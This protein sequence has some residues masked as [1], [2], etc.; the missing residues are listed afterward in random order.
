MNRMFV[1]RNPYKD[2]KYPWVVVFGKY[3]YGAISLTDA[4]DMITRESNAQID[5]R[6]KWPRIP[7]IRG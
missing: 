5:R 1:L 2:K 3:L 6:K 7:K 4:E